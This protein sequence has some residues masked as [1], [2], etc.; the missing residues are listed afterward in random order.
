M[1]CVGLSWLLYGSFLRR[2]AYMDLGANHWSSLLNPPTDFSSLRWEDPTHRWD[3]KAK[4]S[5]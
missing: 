1:L 5:V 3:E 2:I 4:L